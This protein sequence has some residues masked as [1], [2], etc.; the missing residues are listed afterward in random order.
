MAL[1]GGTIALRQTQAARTAAVV[2]ALGLPPLAGEGAMATASYHRPVMVQEVLHYLA[3]RPGGTYLDGTVGEGGHGEAVLRAAQPGGRLLGLDVDP[4]AVAAA[5]QRLAPFGGAARVVHASYA[6]LAEAA[7]VEGFAPLDGVLLD[8]GLSSRQLEAEGR[9]FSFLRDEP[10]DMRYDPTHGPTAA[11]LVNTLPEGE[12]ARLL[13][14]LGEEPRARAI[15]RAL[16][17]ARPLA[18]SGELARVVERAAG[19]ARGRLHPATRTF[20]ALRIAVNRELENLREGLAQAV[21]AL[22]PEGRLVVISYHSLEDRTVKEFLR[23]E[24]RGCVCPPGTP[25]CVC[26]HAPSLR[27]L[28]RKVV[29]PTAAEVAAN[30]RSRS[31]RLRAAARL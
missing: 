3:V 31:A 2:R 6:R 9:G 25:V 26:G 19:G 23:Q 29:T 1:S 11:D 20:Q 13:W 8:L 30:P 28:T 27:L 15:A 10:L 17:R 18:T 24:S 5:R 12:L 22:R 14:E 21:E 4:E 16:V 7:R